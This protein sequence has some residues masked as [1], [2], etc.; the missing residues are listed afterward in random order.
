[1]QPPSS[2]TVPVDIPGIIP[3]L[4]AAKLWKLFFPNNIMATN[5]SFSPAKPID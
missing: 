4:H 3:E 2:I 1:M 5:T